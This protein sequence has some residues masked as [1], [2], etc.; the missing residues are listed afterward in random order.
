MPNRIMMIRPN[1][2]DLPP[3]ELPEPYTI[4]WHRDGDA[5]HWMTIKSASDMHHQAPPDYYER[6]YD[7]HP[8]S[9]GQRQAFLCEPSGKP[10]G[11]VTAW[12][13]ENVDD[14]S[15]GKVNW[16]LIAPQ[17][18][19]RGLS[20]PLLVACCARLAAL[21]HT[22]AALYTLTQRIPAIN[23]YR[24]FGFVPLIR[25]PADVQAWAATN[26]LM[27]H[28]YA[29]TEYLRGPELGIDVATLSD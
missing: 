18:Q 25:H 9:L 4:R 26:P 22:R 13:F 28:P 6:M 12:W 24:S 11:T 10:V 8:D 16:M 2:D 21:G 17:A 15:L 20:K 29:E 7:A 1:L 14:P 3:S 5:Q 27:K 23:L 19:G